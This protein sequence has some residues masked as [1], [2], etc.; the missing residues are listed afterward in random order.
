MILVSLGF[1]ACLVL[2]IGFGVFV[3]IMENSTPT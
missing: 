2:V 1:L 3:L